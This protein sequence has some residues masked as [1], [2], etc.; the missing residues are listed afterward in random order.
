MKDDKKFR[1]FVIVTMILVAVILASNVTQEFFRT[2][3]GGYL[4]RKL[5]FE[6]VIS[7]KGLPMHPADYWKKMDE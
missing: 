7:T 5:Y 6:E 2:E 4:K 1:A 3:I